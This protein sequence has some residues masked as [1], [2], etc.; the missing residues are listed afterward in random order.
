M[1][2][3]YLVNGNAIS[4]MGQFVETKSLP[5]ECAH[6]PHT[7]CKPHQKTLMSEAFLSS[8]VAIESFDRRVDIGTEQ[9]LLDEVNYI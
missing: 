3:G 9:L 4:R 1:F 2:R 8:L 6:A 7:L 5:K